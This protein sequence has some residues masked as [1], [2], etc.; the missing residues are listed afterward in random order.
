MNKYDKA[1]QR[2]AAAARRAAPERDESAPYGFSTR[3]AAQAFGEERR[4]PSAF[5]RLSLRAAA[6]ACLLAVAAVAA[7][8]SAIKCAFEGDPAVA[9]ADDPVAEVVDLGS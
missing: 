5:L 3:V 6:V 4:A 1:W 9:A 2:L 8:Y 7:N